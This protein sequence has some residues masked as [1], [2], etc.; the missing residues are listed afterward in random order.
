MATAKT[1]AVTASTVETWFAR[2]WEDQ[3]YA[4]HA[5]LWKLNQSK[6]KVGYDGGHAFIAPVVLS[7]STN[8][9]WIGRGQTVDTQIQ[10]G[11]QAAAFDWKMLTGS[12]VVPLQDQLQNAGT[13]K[14]ADVTQGFSQQCLD[15][16]A[17]DLTTSLFSDGTGS[18]GQEIVG[19]KGL[20]NNT[21][22]GGISNA[23]YAVWDPAVDDP[24]SEALKIRGGTTSMEYCMLKAAKGTTADKPDLIVTTLSLFQSYTSQVPMPERI[25]N[26]ELADAGF[27]NVTFMGTPI[28]ADEACTAGYMYF[29]N[30]KYLQLVTHTKLDGQN[31]F[32][33][34]EPDEPVNQ[35][36]TIYP[37]TWYGA[38]V[39]NCRRS[40][41]WLTGK[42]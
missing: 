20:M 40:H 42:T 11:L 33:V 37:V 10:T 27:E 1:T 12:V 41:A 25:P 28:I 38:L 14:M 17:N 2:N 23:N 19:L 32:Q 6:A 13:A 9:A 30:T 26:K 18:G 31:G 34:G 5:L 21:T 15:T 7:G 8:T 29:I 35:R 22:Y 36:V 39:S 4:R 16:M 3:V 24:T